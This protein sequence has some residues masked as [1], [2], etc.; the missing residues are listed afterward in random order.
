[1]ADVAHLD[2]A[3]LG[4]LADLA[5]L[6]LSPAGRDEL[7]HDLARI[8]TYLDRLATADDPTLAPLRHP[9]HDGAPLTPDDLRDDVPADGSPEGI[10]AALTELRDGRVVVPRTVDVTA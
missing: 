8:L 6:D 10:L 5:R 9:A 1:M 3:E 2:D 4:H 7:A